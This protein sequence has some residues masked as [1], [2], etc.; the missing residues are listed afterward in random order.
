MKLSK[1]NL[2]EIIQLYLN[3]IQKEFGL[4]S[5]LKSFSK[6]LKVLLQDLMEILSLD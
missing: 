5:G 4:N 2:S 1:N 3:D 6:P